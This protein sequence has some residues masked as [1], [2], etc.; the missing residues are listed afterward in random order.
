MC[1][2]VSRCWVGLKAPAARYG[3]GQ[4][5]CATMTENHPDSVDTGTLKPDPRKVFVI[6]GRNQTARTEVFAFLRSIGLDPIEWSAAL[7][8]TSEASPY[9]GDVLNA[10]FARAQAVVVLQTPDDIAYLDAALCDSDDAEAQPQ[11]QPRPNVL[12]EAGM[13]MGRNPERTV[14]VEF[15]RVKSFSDIHGRH[16]V[17]LDNNV[18]RRQDLAQR[19]RTAGCAVNLD[20]SDWHTAGDLTPPVGPGKG[21]PIGKKVPKSDAPAE[22]QLDGRYIDRGSNK[23][24]GIEVI[25]RGPGDVYELNVDDLPDGGRGMIRDNGNLPVNKLPAGKSVVVLDYMGGRVM[26]E[27]S[28]SHL[29]ITATG[30]TTEGNP[31]KQELFISLGAM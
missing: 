19:L 29:T 13:A 5:E 16:V 4:T 1:L 27:S 14:I 25:N 3:C 2:T 7:R 6:H 15:G 21:L 18:G 30:K 23:L 11:P 9:I 24:G 12:Y 8:M 31:L 10:A 26:G 28:K 20:D 17:R 22:P